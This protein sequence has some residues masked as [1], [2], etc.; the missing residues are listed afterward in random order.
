MNGLTAQQI[1]QSQL[2]NNDPAWRKHFGEDLVEVMDR[3]HS[4]PGRTVDLQ[5]RTLDAT[6]ALVTLQAVAM[7]RENRTALMQWPPNGQRDLFAAMRWMDEKPQVRI[8]GTWYDLVSIDSQ[9]VA[10][11]IASTK[12]KFAADWQN[13]FQTD[14]DATLKNKMLGAGAMV[15]VGLRTLD[16]NEEVMMTLQMPMRN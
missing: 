3:M 5:V 16:S 6:K 12:T 11:L 14:V 2:D 7:T 10:Q 13:Q 15:D 4:R 1:I 9:P 8:S